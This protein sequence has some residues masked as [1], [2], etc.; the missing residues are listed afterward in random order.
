MQDD[1]AAKVDQDKQ[2][3]EAGAAVD[4][5]GLGQHDDKDATD[6]DTK[7]DHPATPSDMGS[8]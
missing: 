3:P 2:S 6:V 4:E 7:Q 8:R 5:Q 1:D